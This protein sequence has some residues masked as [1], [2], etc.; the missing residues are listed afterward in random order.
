MNCI[1]I[2][3]MADNLGNSNQMPTDY[4]NQVSLTTHRDNE[5]TEPTLG[6]QTPLQ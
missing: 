1:M 3:Q 4:G 6:K 2:Q 5:I